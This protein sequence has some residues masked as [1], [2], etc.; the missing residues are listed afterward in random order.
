MLV[1]KLT[2]NQ[3]RNAPDSQP[4]PEFVSGELRWVLLPILDHFALHGLRE[5][6]L[7]NI[8]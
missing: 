6:N 1:L 4:T 3:L 2:S 8:R 7:E 5:V